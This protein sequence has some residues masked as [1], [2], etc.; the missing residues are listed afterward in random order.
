MLTWR[1][2]DGQ[3]VRNQFHDSHQRAQGEGTQQR[4]RRRGLALLVVLAIVVGGVATVAVGVLRGR[5]ERSRMAQTSI[6]EI[7]LDTTGLAA[8]ELMTAEQAALRLMMSSVAASTESDLHAAID[9]LRSQVD[10]PALVDSVEASA[11]AFVAEI[12]RSH[13]QVGRLSNPMSSVPYLSWFQLDNTLTRANEQVDA[14]ATRAGR[15][16]SIGTWLVMLIAGSAISLLAGR[17]A[18]ERTRSRQFAHHAAT[19]ALTGLDNRGSFDQR[20]A[21]AVTHAR[22][23]GTPLSVVLLDVD[24]F[25]SVNDTHGHQRGDDVIVEVARRLRESA[26][27]GDVLA[28]LGGDEYVW[29]MPGVGGD[30]AGALAERTLASIHATP[31]EGVGMLTASVGV[32]SLTGSEGPEGLMRRA[33]DALYAAK[34]GGRGH[35]AHAGMYPTSGSATPVAAV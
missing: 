12:R 10:D 28:R 32:A 17:F 5:L 22:Q 24:H 26:R 1:R 20:L 9:R 11:M 6:S 33:D 16:A 35:V 31:F 8:I 29:L 13:G 25:K 23:L 2:A 14:T 30:D 18:A 21:G 34:R 19:D 27:G 3:C 15:D 4:L 7:R